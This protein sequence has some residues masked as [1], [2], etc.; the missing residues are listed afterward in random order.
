MS[1]IDTIRNIIKDLV[2]VDAIRE[3]VILL[4]KEIKTLTDHNIDLEKKTADLIRENE[5]LR[6]ELSKFR[7]SQNEFTEYR[8]ANFERLPGPG[9]YS[10]S[11]Y[12]PNCLKTMWG[13][14]LFPYECS[15]CGHRADFSKNDLPT[16]LKILGG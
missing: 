13:M 11:V 6:N 5:N 15:K 3:K 8:G 1:T 7:V 14:D 4:E 16:I 2:T 10:E 12:C 9:G